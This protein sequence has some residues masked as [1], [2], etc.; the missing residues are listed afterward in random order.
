MI[1]FKSNK[2]TCILPEKDMRPD[3]NDTQS[4]NH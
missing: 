1:T 4:Q 3:L 2:L